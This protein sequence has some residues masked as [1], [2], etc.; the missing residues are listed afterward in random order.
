M[1]GA[2]QV[3]FI[4]EI[5]TWVFIPFAAAVAGVLAWVVHWILRSPAAK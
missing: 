4:E 3:I 1:L 5:P 2:E